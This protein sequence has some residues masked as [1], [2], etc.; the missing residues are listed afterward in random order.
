MSTANW[1]I[2]LLGRS[3][4]PVRRDESRPVAESETFGP[5]ELS[6]A[7]AAVNLLVGAV[8]RQH[9]IQRSMTF[10]AI[11]ALLVPHGTLGELLLRGEHH[12]ATTGAALSSWRLNRGRI[13]IVIRSTG[14][15]FFLPANK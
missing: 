10:G 7:G 1:D 11:E 15:N 12:A 6:V 9:G 3:V 13:G 5:E 4:I 2:H 8:A 14:R